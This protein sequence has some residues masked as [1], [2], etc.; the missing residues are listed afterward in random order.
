[1]QAA[2]IAAQRGSLAEAME[3]RAHATLL[4]L[5]DEHTP[6]PFNRFSSSYGPCVNYAPKLYSLIY[7]ATESRK[8]VVFGERYFYPLVRRSL[9]TA[10]AATSPDLVISVHPLLTGVPL[11][12]LRERQP[13]TF[14]HGGHRPSHHP[15][16]MVV[17]W[18]DLCVV[19]TEEARAEP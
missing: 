5:L 15:P 1:M 3:G 18:V 8:P 16:G 2:G 7:H 10:L 13:R 4:N 11:R 14:C 17:S 12:V 9:C 6:F 19:A